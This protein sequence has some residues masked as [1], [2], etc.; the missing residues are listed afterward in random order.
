MMR[1]MTIR[2]W[3]A[4]L[5]GVLFVLPALILLGVFCIYPMLYAVRVSL[6]NWNMTSPM[7]YVGFY[8][9]TKFFS[10][11]TAIKALVA[12]L[13]YV[14]YILPA[15]LIIGFLLAL[16]IQRP[17]RA[18]VISRTMIFI[19]H[20]ASVVAVC[21]IW[22]FLFNP[23]Y[24]VINTAL[25]AL[26]LP[27]KRWLNDV[28]TALLSIAIVSIWRQ[29]GYNMIVF[30]GGIQNISQEVLE[31]ARIDGANKAQCV[32]YIT[33]PLVMPT[34][35]MLMILNTISIFKM[36]TLIE[37]LTL[38]GP[39]KSTTNLVYFIQQTAFTDY[40]MGYAFAISVI[41]FV[42]ILLINLFQMSLERFVSYDA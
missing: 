27:G 12:T 42:I 24:G 26:G 9:Y 22:T 31:A 6:Y 18:S 37:N 8:N 1:Q 21:T 5:K 10:N 33:L 15:S 14:L 20:I 40:Q 30:L 39:A 11:R 32:W 34:G 28:N 29:A 35:F 23:Q 25:G 38:G 3:K 2:A 16:M 41:L 19:P 17:G 36:Y 7:R 4:E 13:K